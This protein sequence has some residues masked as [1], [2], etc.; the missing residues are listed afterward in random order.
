MS[1]I[2]N[3]IAK[4]LNN[5]QNYLFLLFLLIFFMGT[6]KYINNGETYKFSTNQE[7]ISIEINNVKISQDI[8]IDEKSYWNKDSYLLYFTIQG[9]VLPESIEITL[10]Q[11]NKIIDSGNIITTSIKEGFNSMNCLDYSKL[12]SGI[13]T[14]IV[15]SENLK[16]NIRL[17]ICENKYNCPNVRI[18]G[19]EQNYTSVQEYHFNYSNAIFKLGILAFAFL[20][21]VTIF[22]FYLSCLENNKTEIFLRLCIIVTYLLLVFIYDGILFIQ[23]TWA[24][25]V[26]NFMHHSINSNPINSIIISDYGYFPLF[27][28]LISIIC[29][30]ILHLSSYVG[31]Y[32]QQIISFIV[33]GYIFSFFL[34]KQFKTLLNNIWRY[35]LCLVLMILVVVKE[36]GALINFMTYGIFIIFLYFLVESNQ[37]NKKEFIFLCVWGSLCCLSKGVYVTLLPFVILILLL[38]YKQFSRRDKIFMSVIAISSFF[39]MLYY[40]TIGSNLIGIGNGSETWSY[41]LKLIL[42]IFVDVPNRFLELFEDKLF[43]LNGISVYIIIIFWILFFYYLIK[44]IFIKYFKD[45]IINKYILVSI[46]MIVYISAQSLFLRLTRYG[47][48]EYPIFSIEFWSFSQ[49]GIG[50]RYEILIF[51]SAFICVISLIKLTS[52]YRTLVLCLIIL[53]TSVGCGR[54]HFRG[55]GNDIYS[56]N[57]TRIADTISNIE[58]FKDIEETDTRIV[59]I[60]PNWLYFKNALCYCFGSTSLSSDSMLNNNIDIIE[61]ENSFRGKLQ[62]TNFK[63]L[64]N[65]AKI[66]QVFINKNNLVNANYYQILLYDKNDKLLLCQTQDNNKYQ[67]FTTFTF[68]KGIS[69]LAKVEILDEFDNPVFIDNSIYIV[70]NINEPLFI[71]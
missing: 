46:I 54:L 30:N 15:S 53:C 57:K 56:A 1:Q 58:L 7:N 21:I 27:Q 26:T 20:I 47:V 70:V 10:M 55:V 71:E 13:A 64:N 31:L 22:G 48:S 12:N 35:F 14:V 61:N 40:F 36:T 4:I 41:Y 50:N 68:D 43:S 51:L 63:S 33:T 59:P 38:F 69:N 52:K 16:S 19:I 49:F 67:R 28:R 17:G 34:K 8:I 23:P 60:Q 2:K 9:E 6:F 32:A 42:H 3:N 11:D 44:E 29:F 5:K 25:S 62:L 37:W 18:D 65:K 39:Q 66:Y 24:E 45:E